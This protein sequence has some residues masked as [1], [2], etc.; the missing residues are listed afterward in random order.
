MLKFAGSS[1]TA[2][3]MLITLNATT[4]SQQ[5]FAKYRKIEAY[6][7]RPGIIMMPKYTADGEVCEIGLER[8]LYSADLVRVSS[9][10]SRGEINQILDELVPAGE[11]G[12]RLTDS[13]YN[14]IVQSGNSLVTNIGYEKV[15]IRIYGVMSPSH[16]KNETTVSEHVATVKWN[17]RMC[18]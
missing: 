7:V 16:R 8:L 10:L 11:R 5:Q 18:R 4:T 12:E 15:S 13:A 2:L 3:V 6:E 1:L 14:Q 17:N 9:N